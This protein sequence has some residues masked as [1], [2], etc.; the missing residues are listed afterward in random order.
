MSAILGVLG[1]TSTKRP[2]D[3]LIVVSYILPPILCYP[4][5]AVL[6][7]TPRTHAIR[8]AIWPIVTLLALR[9]VV[10]E[11]VS[12]GKSRPEAFDTALRILM[13]TIVVRT[14]E[15]TLAKEPLVRHLRPANRAPSTLM[16]ALD[17]ISNLRGHGWNW[18]RGLYVP[19]ET[20]PTHRTL[21]LVYTCLSTI[22]HASL[23]GILH[24]A[25]LTC[26]PVGAIVAIPDGST[27]FDPTLPFPARYL[28]SSILTLCAGFMSYAM[29]QAGYDACTVL[30]LVVLGQDPAQWPPAFDA[31]WRA[32]S[33]SVFWSRRWHQ[34]GRQTF[35]VFGGYPLAAVTVFGRL[36]M[37]IGAFMASAALH[38]VMILSLDSRIEMWWMVVGF[39]MMAFGVLIENAFRE[40]TGWRVGG[41]VGW[42][43]TMTWLALWGSLIMEGFW[44]TG[45]FG[46]GTLIDWV[47]PV[48]VLVERL[49]VDF[50]GWFH[51]I[52]REG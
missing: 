17:L 12:I 23:F 33:L 5:V 36:G 6:A 25:I 41:V 31:P 20:R 38:D 14:F 35:L 51:A 13:F 22:A 21:F 47:S 49:V 46:Y 16:D 52:E 42:I 18:S 11:N 15:W 40:V 37:V 8:V 27:L 28:R 9:A 1:I 26:C 45:I 29:L 7:I 34:W 44:R 24:R 3:V 48:R 39:G 10:S 30:A 4:L 32:T 2:V 19:R 43:W 50:D